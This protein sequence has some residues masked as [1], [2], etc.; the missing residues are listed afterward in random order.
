VFAKKTG[1]RLAAPTLS[2]YWRVVRAASGL[3]HDFYLASKH[4]G[5]HL[6][7]KAGVSTRAICTQMG[8]SEKVV[9]KLLATYGHADIAALDEIDALYSDANPTQHAPGSAS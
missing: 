3:E 6:L 5:V 2:A 4:Y 8:W 9:D 7:F 1:G